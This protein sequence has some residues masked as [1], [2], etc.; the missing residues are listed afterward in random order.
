MSL[1]F[2]PLYPTGM[3]GSNQAESGPSNASAVQP[4]TPAAA[5]AMDEALGTNEIVALIMTSLR[6]GDEDGAVEA[7]CNAV[8]TWLGLNRQHD[9]IGKNDEAMWEMLMQ[10]IFPDAPAPTMHSFYN[11][12][13][14][15]PESHKEW[16][17]AMCY[18]HKLLRD[19]EANWE[20]RKQNLL[21]AKRKERDAEWGLYRFQAAYEADE[22][23]T[24]A[25][26]HR[27]WKQLERKL[28]RATYD[29]HQLEKEAKWF[30]THDLLDARQRM[31]MWHVVPAS[32]QVRRQHTVEPERP[33]SPERPDSSSSDDDDDDD[34]GGGPSS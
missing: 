11:P 4:P 12:E 13:S 31:R 6:A 24:D 9:G 1:P 29:R 16:F 10:N 21:E 5:A 34:E 14:A 27:R 17:Y 32:L 33:W 8:A 30:E 25:K 15:L 19:A 23:S 20:A 18:R 26:L 28:G 2:L 22:L 3:P 7:A